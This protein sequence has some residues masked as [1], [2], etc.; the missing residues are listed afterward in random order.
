MIFFRR[1]Q[2]VFSFVLLFIEIFCERVERNY[3]GTLGRREERVVSDNCKRDLSESRR[4]R[5]YQDSDAKF[6]FVHV[7]KL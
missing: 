5:I 7:K 6:F 1:V 2:R 4:D 3:R